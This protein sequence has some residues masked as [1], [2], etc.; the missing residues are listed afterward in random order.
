MGARELGRLL[1][2]LDSCRQRWSSVVGVEER[3]VICLSPTTGIPSDSRSSIVAGTS[4]SDLMPDE[5]TSAS[6]RASSPRSAEMSMR[7]PRCTPAIPPVPRNPIPA[8]RQAASVPARVV[9]PTAPWTIAA[10]RSRG[11]T[12][13]ASAVE[14]SSSDRR[15]RPERAV[16]HADG[17]GRRTS[18]ARLART[19]GRRQASPSG[20]PSRRAS[21]L[22]RDDGLAPVDRVRHLGQSSI[23]RESSRT[24]PSWRR[25]DARR[26]V[27][28]L[29]RRKVQRRIRPFAA[30]ATRLPLIDDPIGL[31]SDRHTTA[32]FL[33][34]SHHV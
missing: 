10:A 9:A 28:E 12:F 32:G 20:N 19:R 24:R 25:F 14:R 11:P 6:V 1:G 21:F 2:A 30:Q 23:T 34:I 4:S 27:F 13:R 8:A 3:Q 17:C 31:P 18:R 5:T 16:Q 29:S 22:E 15:G 7:L 33:P 26:C